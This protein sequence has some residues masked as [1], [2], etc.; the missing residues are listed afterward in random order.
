MTRVAGRVSTK[1]WFNP[2]LTVE[3][4]WAPSMET[5]P[6]YNLAERTGQLNGRIHIIHGLT[7]GFPDANQDWF[8]M[9][10]K[11]AAG[12]RAHS[13][14]FS[15]SMSVILWQPLSHTSWKQKFKSQ[16][17]TYWPDIQLLSDFKLAFQKY[18]RLF[19]P[20]NNLTWMKKEESHYCVLKSLCCFSHLTNFSLLVLTEVFVKE[21]RYG[22]NNDFRV[23]QTRLWDHI[24]P[25]LPLG[26]SVSLS[27][28][29]AH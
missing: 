4:E 1:G 17:Q 13:R 28:T 23:S 20:W 9:L 24:H 16:I 6:D 27:L 14:E 25:S 8:I 10:L 3:V 2:R 18:P 26:F 19:C 11:A 5:L 7:A 15:R 12:R 22:T 29:C 21:N